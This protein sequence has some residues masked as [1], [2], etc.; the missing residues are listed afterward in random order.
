MIFIEIGEC[1]AIGEGEK[2]IL[3]TYNVADHI[4]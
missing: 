2:F 4:D 3:S 1:F